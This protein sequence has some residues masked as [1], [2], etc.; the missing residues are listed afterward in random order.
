MREL[1]FAER[2]LLKHTDFLNWK[3]DNNL[4][5]VKMMRKFMIQRREDYTLYN[6][7]AWEVRE[8]SR[9]I[10]DLDKNDPFRVEASGR[11]LEKLYTMGIIPT[12]WNLQLCDKVTAS[13][14]CR[15][16][17][18][19][20]MVRTK[21]APSLRTALTFIEQGHVRVGA[22]VVKDPA[23]LVNRNLEDYVTWVDTSAIRKHVKQYNEE[24]DDF[25][26]N[27]C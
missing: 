18:P 4:H 1:K 26:L 23:F 11:L 15:R 16:R 12:K 27:N 21:M 20:V 17:L 13:S 5:E 3:V 2:K 19:C 24:R 25:V 6:K 14:F 22:E 8:L 7:M 9:K 10:K